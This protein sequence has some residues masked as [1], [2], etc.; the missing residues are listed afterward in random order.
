MTLGSH[1]NAIDKNAEGD[2]LISSRHTETIY[3]I[4]GGNGSILWQLGGK[5]SDFQQS[6]YNFSYQHDAR[7]VSENSTTTVISLFDNAYN[8]FNSSADFSEGKIISIDNSTMTSKLVKTYGAPDPSGGLLS[9]SQG[10]I[11]FL[12]DGNVFLGWGSNAFISE[13]T[14]D[15]TPVLYAHFATT[16]ALHYRAYKFDFTGTPNTSPALYTYAHNTSAST[17]FY[18]SWNGA[19]EVASWTFYGGS[20]KNSMVKLGNVVR[21][22]FETVSTQPNFYAYSIAEAVANNGSVLRN[23]SIMSTFVP[24]STLAT[25]CTD[26]QCPL[27]GGYQVEPD[28][29]AMTSAPIAPTASAADAATGTPSS[30]ASSAGEKS[31]GNQDAAWR[32]LYIWS[33]ATVAVIWL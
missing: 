32:L 15:G 8:G 7:F 2:Y 19:T 31:A 5:T 14:A 3:K 30:V 6:G 10:N 4:S 28:I 25:A 22:G 9:A 26:I 23:S 21:N 17:A 20:S 16:G 18:V 13:S 27:I 29:L 33:T 1:I 11:Q 24:G 12:P